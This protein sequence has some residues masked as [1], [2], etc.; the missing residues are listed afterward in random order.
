MMIKQTKVMKLA[1]STFDHWN[2]L[3]TKINIV[4][5]EHCNGLFAQCPRGACYE[6]QYLLNIT[7]SFQTLQAQSLQARD[8]AL[9]TNQCWWPISSAAQVALWKCYNRHSSSWHS[10]GETQDVLVHCY[11]TC[12][13]DGLQPGEEYPFQ[14]F[15][16][17][18]MSTC[19]MVALFEQISQHTWHTV[20]PVIKHSTAYF[21]VSDHNICSGSV[22]KVGSYNAVFM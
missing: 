21:F 4:V 9:C 5:F 22:C 16:I 1:Y 3:L 2:H 8:T 20:T 11:S 19:K 10:V 18:S 7:P 13:V 6:S 17:L 14:R 15:L 12:A